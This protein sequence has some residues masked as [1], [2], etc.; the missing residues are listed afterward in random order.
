MFCGKFYLLKICI[1][2]LPR[3]METK[4]EYCIIVE[5]NYFDVDEAE[6]ALREPFIEEFVE[7]NGKFRLHN[8][9]DIEVAQGIS[10]GDLEIEMIDDEVFQISSVSRKIDERKAKMLEESLKRQA[11]FDE[12]RI[13]QLK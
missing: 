11:M 12:I 4:K 5:G 7:E 9:D 1:N 6:D 3:M 10:L 8:W 2:L 13:E